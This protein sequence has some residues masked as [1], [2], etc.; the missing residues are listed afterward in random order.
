MKINKST[1]A[2]T[3]LATLGLSM[4]GQA[5]AGE[6]ARSYLS[7]DNLQLLI[8]DD[9]GVT[10]GGNTLKS[11]NFNLTNSS[12]L[13]G[14]TIGSGDFC[15]GVGP[16][17]GNNN[18]GPLGARVDALVVTQGAPAQGEN[19]FT[20]NGPGV[21]QYSNADSV[22]YQT[23]LTGD[24]STSTE[25]IA[26]AEIQSIS[27][28]SSLADISSTT[29]FTFKFTVAGANVVAISFG[30]AW[31]KLVDINDP[32]AATATS[33]AN[34]K[35]QFELS[36]DA[37]GD[38]VIWAPTGLGNDCAVLGL[39]GACVTAGA[40]NLNEDLSIA[41]VP[42][43]TDAR[44]GAGNFS[45]FFD[46]LVDGEWSLSLNAVTSTLVSRTVPEP[47]LLIMLGLGLAGLGATSIRRKKRV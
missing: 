20:F 9:G 19:T 6:Y 22:I 7:I 37:T 4:A 25:Q 1:L 24:G 17:L 23:Q 16:N 12:T 13:G 14:N 2:A 18:C 27:N 38:K 45:M 10:N 44:A 33:Q 26:E 31:D 34:A 3:V 35:V 15:A 39:A 46:G 43:S 5:S 29:G 41:T 21:G 40:G 8:S 36:N 47:S 30:A 32:T 28:A 42:A 11:F